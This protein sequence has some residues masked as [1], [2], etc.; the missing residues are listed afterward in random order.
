MKNKLIN[1]LTNILNNNQISFESI[2]LEVPKNKENGDYSTNIALKLAKTLH[3]SPMEIAT[4]IQ[5]QINLTSNQFITKVEIANPGF[6]NFYLDKSYL[7]SIINEVI[8]SGADYGRSNIGQGNN[9]NI[10]FVSANP[11]GILH[12]GNAR[13]GAYGDS[14]ARILRFSGY[15]VTEEYYVNDAGNQINNL[16]L[17]I[18]ARYKT[19]CGIDTPLP[20]NGYHGNEIITIA[21]NLY[22]EYQNTLLDNPLDYFKDLG[23]NILLDKIKNVLK[24]YRINYDIYT[25]EKDI[26]KKHPLNEIINKLQDNGY[27]YELDGAI[28]LKATELGDTKDHVLVKADGSYT[29]L[30]PDI[31]YHI[32]KI[33]RN[34]THLIDVFGTDHHGYVPRLKGALKALGYN[35]SILDVKLLQLVRLIKDGEEVKMSKRTGKIVSLQELID[36][37]GINATR[38]FF[39]SRSLDTQ[40]DFDLDL[41]LKTSNDNPVY[42]ISYAY[43]RICSILNNVDKIKTI[44]NYHTLNSKE[45]YNVLEMLE[46]FPSVVA[47]SATK[48]LPHLISNYVYDLASTFHTY[49][50]KH[51]IITENEEETN[52]QLNLILAVKITLA[53][54]LNLIGIIPPEKM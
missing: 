8:A 16:A 51:R 14:L 43:A 19:I 17:S 23:T 53:N 52:E 5:E 11:T 2:E 10:E 26:Y 21:E 45:A 27:T 36:L 33:E 9:Y 15:N 48:E 44:D 22:K 25:S 6:I 54:A 18:E 41:A 39:V 35:E 29:Y 13:G 47:S 46:K 50:A 49:Y 7:L 32:D 24:E 20:E 42:Y 28:W 4:S 31:A 1:L 40:M 12:L 38:Y 34:Y 37:V 3:K 30:V